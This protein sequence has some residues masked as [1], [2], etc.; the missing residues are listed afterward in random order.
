MQGP[1]FQKILL[2]E[3]RSFNILKV[4]R[5]YFVVPWH[6]HPEVEIMLVM[7]GHGT[8]F[9][10]DSIERFEPYDL[11]MVGANL[12]HVWKN[13]HE[14]FVEDSNA[15]AEARVILF[16]DSCFGRNFFSIPEMARI[17]E[18]LLRAER[19]IKF[20]GKTKEMVAD[21]IVNAYELD[22]AK[23]F[24]A[25]I[26]ILDELSLT[27]EYNYLCCAGYNQK[28][29]ASDLLRLNSVLDYMMKNFHKSI[30]LE[31]VANVANLTPN[32]FCR[33][34]KTRTNKTVIQF[35]NELRVG[36][37]HKLLVETQS[38]I[39]QIAFES[40]FHN[41]SNFYE[42]FQKITGKSP[43]KFRKEH[44]QKVFIKTKDEPV[45]YSMV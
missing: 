5:S 20:E 31:D 24:A 8:R 14:H 44:N 29:Q 26:G 17:S 27:E 18:L 32:A 11:V 12:A 39:D 41:L 13:N 30:K 23:Q 37:A 7:R 45:K 42:Q 1:L 36:Y 38:N 43:F 22:G 9:V 19:G 2:K 10:G 3:N 15:I 16:Q 40:G 33:Y 25:L 35:V 28:V 21:L 4:E 34:F 6:F